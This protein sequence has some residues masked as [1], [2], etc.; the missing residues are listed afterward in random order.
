MYLGE[1]VDK[2]LEDESRPGRWLG[3]RHAGGD[4]ARPRGIPAVRRGCRER[5]ANTNPVADL[6]GLSAG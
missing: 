1:A 5:S 6:T 4:P 3:R 2:R